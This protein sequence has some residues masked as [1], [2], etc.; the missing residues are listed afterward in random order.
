MRRKLAALWQDH[1]VSTTE[2][3][4]GLTRGGGKIQGNQGTGVRTG[5][6]VDFQKISSRSEA[7][8]NKLTAVYQKKLDKLG[9]RPTN[10]MTT[11]VNNKTLTNTSSCTLVI[12]EEIILG[13]GLKLAITP[14]ET[15][16]LSMISAA[17]ATHV[18]LCK[19]TF[20]ERS[21]QHNRK[22]RIVSTKIHVLVD[23]S[24]LGKQRGYRK[25]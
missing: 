25:I 1:K 21:H 12:T 19:A 18:K 10:Q 4:I 24:T 17:E 7:T 13:E 14:K 2:A 3:S 16:I 5:L 8:R 15:P 20:T 23:S 11:P 9:H 22:R 6:R